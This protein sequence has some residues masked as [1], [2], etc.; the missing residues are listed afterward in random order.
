R[1][2]GQFTLQSDTAAALSFAEMRVER[3][4]DSWSAHEFLGDVSAAMGDTDQAR[5]HYRHSLDLK[6]GNEQVLEKLESLD[7]RGGSLP[8]RPIIDPGPSGTP[9]Q[10]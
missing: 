6:P 1:L 5:T 8:H 10:E 4:P 2:L 7:T 3:F 9:S